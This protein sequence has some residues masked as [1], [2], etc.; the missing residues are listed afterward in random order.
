MPRLGLPQILLEFKTKGLTA[1][2]RSARGI[3]AVILQDDTADTE[4]TV[5]R[6]IDEIS[7]LD[8][9]EQNY[10][11]LNLIFY[12]CPTKV[13]V[14]R[15]K[16][17]PVNYNTA[18]AFLKTK[19]WNYLTIPGIQPSQVMTVSAFIKSQRVNER[20]TFKA[21]LPH[22]A[23]DSEGVINFCTEDIKISDKVYTAA[24]YC[25]RIAGVLAGLPLS[26]SSTYF[27]FPEIKSAALS[28]DPDADIDDGKL[29]LIFDG[30]KYKIARGVNSFTSFTA[31][32]G[33]DFCKI[34]IVEGVDLYHDDIR[35]TFNKYYVGKVINDYDNKQLFVAA[36][37]AYHKEL[38]GNVLDRSNDNTAAISLEGQRNYL[39]GKGTDTSEMSNVE[40]LKGNTGSKVFVDSSVKFVDAMEDLK[41]VVY[42]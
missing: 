11:Y 19:K 28:D 37:K 4:Y 2:Q 29:I 27:D 15:I 41:M 7:F 10:D 8:W 6:S 30:S 3:V 9:T 32:M 39:E 40:I 31:E 13:L 23:A 34:K 21:V 42:M 33:E 22:I 14:Y 25:T 26:R 1:I 38:E 16:E 17:P 20:K 5:Y 18:L 24:E 12:G 35:D 36:I